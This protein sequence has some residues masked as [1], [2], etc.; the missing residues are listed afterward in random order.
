MSPK[1]EAAREKYF[2]KFRW[3]SKTLAGKFS[4]RY[5]KTYEEVLDHADFALALEL[6]DRQNYDPA[7]GSLRNWLWQTVHWHL[8]QI[9]TRGWH[10]RLK[11]IREFRHTET[12]INEVDW[13]RMGTYPRTKK[14]WLETLLQEVSEEGAVLID[15]ILTAP[16]EIIDEFNP[17]KIGRPSHR[18]RKEAVKSYLIDVLDWDYRKFH[19][20]WREVEACL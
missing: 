2:L 6:F 11:G 19:R 17:R 20:A 10:P 4:Q 8:T 13:K 15:T 7:K 5:K 16:G 18:R 9:Y 1:M 3:I 14:N 12:S